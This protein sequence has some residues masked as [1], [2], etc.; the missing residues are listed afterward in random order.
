LDVVS[1]LTRA[2]IELWNELK[3]KMLPTPAKFH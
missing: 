3:A 1:K 2:S